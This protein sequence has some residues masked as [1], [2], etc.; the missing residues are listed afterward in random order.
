MP[1]PISSQGES[2]AKNLNEE[3]NAAS[4][5]DSS[6]NNRLRGPPLMLNQQQVFFS[7]K[8]I[9]DSQGKIIDSSTLQS[10]T[11]EVSSR[12]MTSHAEPIDSNVLASRGLA[13]ENSE[14]S[15]L[16]SMK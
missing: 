7:P 6:P 16:N 2:V 15:Q 13:T 8:V 5:R 12:M 4:D 1:E 3:L 9:R 11:D 14:V 10:P